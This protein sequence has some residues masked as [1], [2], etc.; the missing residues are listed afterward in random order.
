LSSL[1]GSSLPRRGLAVR[2][3]AAALGRTVLLATPVLFLLTGPPWLFT[4]ADLSTDAVPAG[5]GPAPAGSVVAGAAGIITIRVAPA[6]PWLAAAVVVMAFDLGHRLYRGGLRRAGA[7]PVDDESSCW[8]TWYALAVGLV[9]LAALEVTVGGWSGVP[10]RPLTTAVDL[11]AMGAGTAFLAALVTMPASV[12]AWARLRLLVDGAAVG[13]CLTFAGWA[14]LVAPL[15]PADRRTPLIVFCCCVLAT[16]LVS[17]ADP[18]RSGHGPAL[19]AAG[20]GVAMAGLLGLSF[21][22]ANPVPGWWLAAVIALLLAAPVLGWCGVGVLL[23]EDSSATAPAAGGDG[24]RAGW[25]GKNVIAWPGALAVAVAV[26]QMAIGAG[27]DRTSALLGTL[28]V[29]AVGL[30][31]VL[32]RLAPVP[33]PPAS[34]PGVADGTEGAVSAVPRPRAGDHATRPPV[35]TD[36]VTGL[37]DPTQLAWSITA[38]RSAPRSPGALLLIGIDGLDRVPGDR[39]D[40]VVRE[41]ATRLRRFAAAD[42]HHRTCLA[43][44]P[45]RWSA[46][47]LALLTPANLAQA[48]GLAH[49]VLTLLADPVSVPGGTSPLSVCVGLTDLAGATS[50][51]DAVRRAQVALRRARQLGPGRVEWY[52]PAVAEV[53]ARREVLERDLPEAIRRGEL[54]LIYQPI[55]DLERGRP[56]AVEA[57]LRWRHPQLGTLLPADVIPIAEETGAI[58]DVDRWAL[59]RA[60]VRLAIWRQEDRDVAMAINVSPHTLATSSFADEVAVALG[61]Y[62]LPPNRLVVEVAEAEIEDGVAVDEGVAALRAIGVRTALD[63]FGS[64]VASLTHLRR[65]PIDMVKIGKPFFERPA[66]SGSET[67]MID[68]MVGV[69]RRLGV[70]VVAQGVEAP[71]HLTVVR[72]AGC[73]IGQGHLFAR[74]QP[75]EQT[76]A[77]LDGFVV[78]S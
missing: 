7:R 16:A 32:G 18:W 71:A 69:G 8:R 68:L 78:R 14:L 42:E 62:D 64:G 35:H 33:R 65:L 47:E 3:A 11:T 40:D 31:H 70:D 41:V 2:P 59:W 63:A 60:L 17:A 74:P 73:R 34:A 39:H 13:L 38:M 58:V 44:L 15:G 50:T 61:A 36:P 72:S 49:R 30:R 67:P 37:A 26:Y 43:D 27:I 22:L 4:H 12:D 6:V 5:L 66:G 24:A 23:A 45:A 53:V 29:V 57:L 51:E 75:A 20:V 28:A 46:A 1:A 19:C 56:L 25:V 55:L 52:D 54:D 76:E 21:A 77:Y 10:E 48:Y 9:G